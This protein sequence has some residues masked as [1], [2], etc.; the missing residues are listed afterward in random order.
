MLI[1]PVLPV[2]LDIHFVISDSSLKDLI[3]DAALLEIG[4]TKRKKCK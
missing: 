4:K 1:E 2:Q 3:K